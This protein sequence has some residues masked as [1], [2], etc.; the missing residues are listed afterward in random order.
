[1]NVASAA[2]LTALYEQGKRLQEQGLY[3]QAL[4]MFDQ[5]ARLQPTNPQVYFQRGLTLF[6]MSQ[7]KQAAA[8][9]R[10]ALKYAPGHANI[11][12]GLGNCHLALGEREKATDCFEKALKAKPD[13]TACLYSLVLINRYHENSPVIRTLHQFYRSPSLPVREKLIVCFALGNFYEQQGDL[14]KAFPYYEEGNRLKLS[15]FNYDPASH[16]QLMDAIEATFTPDLFK[17]LQ[18]AGSEDATPIFIIG[19]PRSGTSLVEQILASHSGVCGIGEINAFPG[20]AL[21]SAP[22]ATGQPFPQCAGA[23]QPQHCKPLAEQYLA[24]LRSYA[25][26]HPAHICDKLPNNI[27]FAGLIPIVLPRARIIHCT[28]DAMDTCWSFYKHL[29]FDR[30]PYCYDQKILGGF[31]CR[32]VKLME[33]WHRVMPGAVHDMSYDELVESP[34][35]AIRSMLDYCGLEWQDACLHFHRTKRPVT[36][37]STLQVRRPLY[38]DAQ[39]NWQPVARQ[40]APLREALAPCWQD[41]E[42]A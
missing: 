31:Y 27:L 12:N 36:T 2:S 24:Q 3:T 35:P 19:M 42:A 28:R 1:M 16:M 4:A 41:S 5:L 13:H 10:T 17:R 23:L 9:Y 39:K 22:A 37:A 40:L 7:P 11:Y 29:F 15:Q 20:V 30:H 6:Q 18:G 34:E 25:T 14:P 21:G 8:A 32:Y 38:K 26:G 33:H